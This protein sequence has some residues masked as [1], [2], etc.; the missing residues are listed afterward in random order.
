MGGVIELHVVPSIVYVV[1]NKLL[2]SLI[3][4][5]N[6]KKNIVI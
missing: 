2:K 6:E 1:K 5:K 3:K 4:N